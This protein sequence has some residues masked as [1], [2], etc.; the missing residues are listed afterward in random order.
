[1]KKL[2]RPGNISIGGASSSFDWMFLL[3]LL[4]IFGIAVVGCPSMVDAQSAPFGPDYIQL[5]EP[6]GDSDH[7]GA[8]P[9]ATVDVEF[10][11]GHLC[12]DCQF[13]LRFDDS[14]EW[15]LY[16]SIFGETRHRFVWTDVTVGAHRLEVRTSREG[17]LCPPP[18]E[19]P[20]G[21]SRY[22]AFTVLPD[23][24]IITPPTGLRIVPQ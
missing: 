15:V 14:T 17:V 24:T 18:T 13:D 5:I 11:W 21:C 2:K 16:V 12:I 9:V 3:A 1:V 22:F 4:A 19:R 23:G 6:D 10:E 8:N 20:E 7:R